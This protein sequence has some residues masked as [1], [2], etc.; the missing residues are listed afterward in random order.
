MKGKDKGPS[1][2]TEMKKKEKV[3]ED[4][5]FGLK[6]KNKSAKVQKFVQTVKSQVMGQNVKGGEEKRIADEFKKKEEKKKELEQKALLASL[7][8]GVSNI[9]QT[10]L[11]EGE[12]PKSVLCAYFK[13]GVCEKGKKCKFSHDLALDGKAAKIDLYS[14]PRDKNG[15]DPTRTDI[16]CQ[17]FLEAVEKNLY[18]WLWECPNGGEKCVYTHAL[19]PGYILQRDKKDLEKAALE[20][21]EDELTLEEK[22]EEERA[23]LPS[24]GLTPVTLETF[25]DWKK[26]KA[27]RK[28]KELEAKM[29]EEEKKGAKGKNIMSGKALFK[30]DPTLFK[31]DEDAADEKIY[32]EREELEEEKE[33][34]S[35]AVYRDFEDGEMLKSSGDGQDGDATA[36]TAN[37]DADLFK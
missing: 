37:V 22:I 13:A 15:K 30:Y 21:M 14:D 34:E 24:T 12:D 19:P 6:N 23:A 4:K 3:A 26:R 35:K 17:H 7:F 25:Q 16:T 8:K 27:E 31:D 11:R 33:E 10:A 28:Q 5:T 20:D 9:Q 1:K 18:G 36:A 32:E 29:K 2:K